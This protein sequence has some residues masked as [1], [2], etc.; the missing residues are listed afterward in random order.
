MS[1]GS[2]LFNTEDILSLILAELTLK[3][4]KDL[5]PAHSTFAK[6]FAA[7]AYSKITW[8]KYGGFER[9]NVSHPDDHG[10]PSEMLIVSQQW[11][12]IKCDSVVHI[13]VDESKRQGP[14]LLPEKITQI[15]QRFPNVRSIYSI[16]QRPTNK[17]WEDSWDIR[18]EPKVTPHYQHTLLVNLSPPR[19]SQGVLL[20]ANNFPNPDHLKHTP[21]PGWN[22][23]STLAL[24]IKC[25]AGA[26]RTRALDWFTSSPMIRTKIS[27]LHLDM[28]STLPEVTAFLQKRGVFPSNCTGV[29]DGLDIS[30]LQLELRGHFPH[31]FE[32]ASFANS[33][34]SNLVRWCMT[35]DPRRYRFEDPELA[36]D[37][38][39]GFLAVV[40][41]KMPQLRDL[42]V[43][44]NGGY[45]KIHKDVRTHALNTIQSSGHPPLSACKLCVNL[46][47][48]PF[49]YSNDLIHLAVILSQ[50]CGPET[51]IDFSFSAY[52]AGMMR[53]PRSAPTRTRLFKQTIKKIF[54]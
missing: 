14:P 32:L 44:V 49:F 12:A 29:N 19:D 4:L 8:E 34:G 40:A 48:E 26:W 37:E 13:T 47:D 28:D 45:R 24:A 5:A 35:H 11:G 10:S 42:T 17:Y 6:H 38:L 36:I 7:L 23:Q 20:I 30:D 18:L 46:A 27:V 54:E 33:V 21:W 51:V 1:A 2:Q 41:T 52:K 43:F 25:Q 9:D 3:D 22:G 16:A 39:P 53:H 50:I 31:G 15:Q